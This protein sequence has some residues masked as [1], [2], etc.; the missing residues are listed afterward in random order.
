MWGV[1]DGSGGAV[2]AECSAHTGCAVCM[3]RCGERSFESKNAQRS[4]PRQ[5]KRRRRKSRPIMGGNVPPQPKV[6]QIT[7]FETHLVPW[8]ATPTAFGTTAA[9]VTALTT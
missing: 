3:G 2:C 9:A 6:Q 4:K 8:A 7:W 1:Y 5:N